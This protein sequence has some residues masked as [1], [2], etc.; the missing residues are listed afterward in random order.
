[1][2]NSSTCDVCNVGVHR[3]SMHKH[4]RSKKHLE[5]LR[6]KG[7]IK[8]EWFF[9]EQ[10]PPFKKEIKK[11]YNPKTLKQIATEN[12]KINVKELDKEF[13]KKGSFHIL[14]LMKN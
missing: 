3:A 11:V 2:E 12:T 5:I 9:K 4:L 13:V 8:A 10:Q 1:M 7:M 14:S 6:K